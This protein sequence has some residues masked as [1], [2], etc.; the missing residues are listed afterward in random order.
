MFLHVSASFNKKKPAQGN[1]LAW[2]HSAERER[3]I[4][5]G[6]R[7][8]TVNKNKGRQADYYAGMHP[9]LPQSP[10]NTNTAAYCLSDHNIEYDLMLNIQ[11]VFN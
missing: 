9:A 8:F 7:M 11:Y 5:T 6:M 2:S 1:M 4:V 10:T 3:E